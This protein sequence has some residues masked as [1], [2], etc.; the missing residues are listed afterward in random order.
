MEAY[1]DYGLMRDVFNGLQPQEALY[2]QD[3]NKMSFQNPLY[4]ETFSVKITQKKVSTP[5]NMR[6]KDFLGD[7]LA[8]FPP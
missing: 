7:L 8:P 1:V 3:G 6:L 2:I 4:N 5:A